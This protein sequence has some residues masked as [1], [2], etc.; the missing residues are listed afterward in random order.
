MHLMLALTSPNNNF[1]LS[2]LSILKFGFVDL[3][4][5]KPEKVVGPSLEIQSCSQELQPDFHS[6]N[7]PKLPFKPQLPFFLE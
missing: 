1:N 3:F 6:E 2:I 7:S 5:V 4:G